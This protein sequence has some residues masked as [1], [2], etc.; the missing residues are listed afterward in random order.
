VP[1][2]EFSREWYQI[3]LDPIAPEH[4]E[5]EVAFIERQLPTA[6]YPSLLDVCC[7]PGRHAHALA[8]RGYRV[9]GVDA[10]PAAV[11]RA[12][13]GA[14]SGARFRVLDMRAL[15]SL[16]ESFDVVTNLWHSFGYF[17][18]AGN[19]DA[20]RQM[21]ARLEPNGRLLIDVYNRDHIAKLPL[22]E[23]FERA[24]R[25]VHS[26]RSWDGPRH[27]VELQY[28]GGGSDEVEFRLYDP[29]ELA[30]L[31][32]SVGL[33]VVLACAW[34]RESLPPSAEHARM[35]FLFRSS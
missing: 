21:A 32:A 12:A 8:E 20:L 22:R 23:S 26:Q 25:L 27:R 14:A 13:A 5:A 34:F 17:D 18:D 19:R 2:N 31:G 15:D 24:G 3:F 9:L 30:D 7:G 10:N 33:R 28:E 6:S 4:T 29:S 35:Q 1:R 11:T 16:P